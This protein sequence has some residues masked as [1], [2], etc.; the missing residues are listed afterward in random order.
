VAEST[1]KGQGRVEVW[2][3]GNASSR[4]LDLGL[5]EKFHREVFGDVFPE[6]AGRL[7]GPAPR[8]LPVNVHFGKFRGE[9]YE[10]VPTACGSLFDRVLI[11]LRQ[12][13]DLQ[14][15]LDRNEFDDE[16]LK[17]A[18]YVHCEFVRIHP[19]RNG[20]G[21][22]AR[23]CINYFAG[24]C[25]MLAVSFDWPQGE[26]LEANRAWLERRRIEPFVDLLRPLWRRRPVD[27]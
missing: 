6:F 10:E 21:R 3:I 5:I 27:R 17:V 14:E 12:L 25:G 23:M 7:R 19:F 18:A 16:V 11:L 9:A 26:Y 24:R 4:M 8:Y 22:I 13:D 15:S 1:A 20:N 2:L